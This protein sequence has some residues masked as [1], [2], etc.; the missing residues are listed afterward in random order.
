VNNGLNLYTN[1]QLLQL[2]TGGSNPGPAGT[3]PLNAGGTL[4]LG[5]I[6]PSVLQVTP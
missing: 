1:G 2:L 5:T 4:N 6:D 3:L